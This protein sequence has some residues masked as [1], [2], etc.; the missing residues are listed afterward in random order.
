MKYHSILIMTLPVT[1][2]EA[3]SRVLY[4]EAFEKKRWCNPL[5]WPLVTDLDMAKFGRN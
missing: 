2:E 3:L 1:Y 4:Y 5:D